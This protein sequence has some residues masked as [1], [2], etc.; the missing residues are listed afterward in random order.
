MKRKFFLGVIFLAIVG[1]NITLPGIA[2]ADDLIVIGNRSVPVSTLT[3]KEV[4]MIYLGQQKMWDNGL[5]VVFVKLKDDQSCKRFLKHFVKKS[6]K[7]YQRYWNKQ[8]FS[9]GGNPPKEFGREKDL[10][11]YVSQT[12][13]AIGFISSKSYS[14]TVKIL[15]VIH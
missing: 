4:K 8:A 10:V 15:S 2:A 1:M 12:K 7:M 9:G 11:Q 5:K 14:D 13:G 6:P 3:E